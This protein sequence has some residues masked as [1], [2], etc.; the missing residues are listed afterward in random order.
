MKNIIASVAIATGLFAATPQA[1]A[2]DWRPQN[3]D[4]FEDA[5]NAVVKEAS[6]VDRPHH[7]CYPGYCFN[8][9]SYV[10]RDGVA[11]MAYNLD[12]A[13]GNVGHEICE[14]RKGDVP[15][16]N[17]RCWFSDGRIY[18]MHWDGKIWQTTTT[19]ADS[20][21]DATGTVSSNTGEPDLK[22]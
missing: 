8:T 4:Q 18:D 17:R 22:M 2:A 14:Q 13:N 7:V 15:L 1:Y 3:P 12:F 19:V 20:Y 21:P 10:D 6:K 9:M 16:N 11:V 5:Y